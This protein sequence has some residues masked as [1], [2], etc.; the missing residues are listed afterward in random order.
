[1]RE[2]RDGDSSIVQK[3]LERDVNVNCEELSKNETP[4]IWAA[5]AKDGNDVIRLLIEAGANVDHQNVK[6]VTPLI[7]AAMR[8][9]TA[10]I[11]TLIEH[12]ASIHAESHKGDTALSLC[13]WKNHAE[14][15]QVLVERGA[16]VKHVD[17]FGDTV[18]LDAAKHGNTALL[19]LLLRYGC[20][21]D[22]QN[23]KGETALMRASMKGHPEAVRM[24]I[25]RGS[26]MS[27]FSKD[28]KRNAL[29]Y[30]IHHKHRDVVRVL[31]EHR[32]NM[33]L[34]NSEGKT[35]LMLA[36]E[37]EDSDIVQLLVAHAHTN[38]PQFAWQVVPAD[39]DESIVPAKDTAAAVAATSTS[40]RRPLS[41]TRAATMQRDLNIVLPSGRSVPRTLDDESFA[42]ATNDIDFLDLV[43]RFSRVWKNALPS[44]RHTISVALSSLL[45]EHSRAGR[46]T[47]SSRSRPSSRSGSGASVSSSRSSSR[48]RSRPSSR[49]GFFH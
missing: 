36:Y 32:C 47:S 48:S 11:D 30:A 39:G 29:F 7:A 22:H 40:T 1:M 28:G 41:P 24:L 26:N 35:A 31:L 20:E 10:N 2:C 19:D 15:A 33:H 25:G 42:L 49:R 13:V 23:K 3:L 12:G 43:L 9:N 27:I 5:R 14:A 34:P 38:L 21:I 16:N 46:F 8:G 18:L 44:K 37:A 45:G 6:G 4:L 17:S